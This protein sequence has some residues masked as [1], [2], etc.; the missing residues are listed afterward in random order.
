[1]ALLRFSFSWI[2]FC[3]VKR[4][5][6]VKKAKNVVVLWTFLN[7]PCSWRYC[8]HQTV[9]FRLWSY[10]F[11]SLDKKKKKVRGNLQV[12]EE[13]TLI[14][15]TD[16]EGNS[17]FRGNE[18]SRTLCIKHWKPIDRRSNPADIRIRASWRTS[19]ALLKPELLK[20]QI[21]SLSKFL[22]ICFHFSLLEK[23]TH[24][25]TGGCFSCHS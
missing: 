5:E 10:F 25:Q 1:M 15:L 13:L 24:L 3:D 14:S 11:T 20:K 22:I 4:L 6:I 23:G 7:F 19:D 2:W 21:N 18:W 12:K 16:L 9:S 17:N 8:W